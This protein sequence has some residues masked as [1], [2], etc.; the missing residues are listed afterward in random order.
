MISAYIIEIFFGIYSLLLCIV[1]EIYLI[2]EKKPHFYKFA[3][4]IQLDLCSLY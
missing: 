3:L 1:C 4:F 2:A